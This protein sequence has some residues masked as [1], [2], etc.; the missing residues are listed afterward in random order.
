MNGRFN[1]SG[2]Q[3]IIVTWIYVGVFVRVRGD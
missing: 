2:A 1:Q 3:D